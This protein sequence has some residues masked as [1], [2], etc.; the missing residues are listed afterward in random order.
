[1]QD[2]FKTLKDDT[3]F[4]AW[5]IVAL[6]F[7][8]VTN[9]MGSTMVTLR[10]LGPAEW[11]IAVVMGST[12]VYARGIL[13]KIPMG[14][15]KSLDF[16]KK[17]NLKLCCKEQDAPKGRGAALLAAAEQESSSSSS[18]ESDSDDGGSD[19]DGSDGGK[20][21]KKGKGQKSQPGTKPTTAAS[22]PQTAAS[23]ASTGK[24]KTPAQQALEAANPE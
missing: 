14:F 15:F 21:K 1:V 17:K 3:I 24:P 5:A 12:A 23:R 20:K 4:L 2:V 10:P 6:A 22:K 7:N 16:W 18:E 19:D 11:V 13:R 9:I 8:I